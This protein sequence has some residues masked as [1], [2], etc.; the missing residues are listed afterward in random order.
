LRSNDEGDDEPITD[1]ALNANH[2]RILSA[3]FGVLTPS[4]SPTSSVSSCSITSRTCAIASHTPRAASGCARP[5]VIPSL[6]RRRRTSSVSRPWPGAST[7]AVNSSSNR[8]SG[9]PT[10][11]S[12]TQQALELSARKRADPRSEIGLEPDLV[13][14]RHG[15]A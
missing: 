7:P 9:L 4:I 13:R 10:S 8:T 15:L 14:Q 2:I 5:I 6:S 1:D 11:A 12:A 3:S